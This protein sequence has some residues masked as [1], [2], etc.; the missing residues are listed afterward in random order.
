MIWKTR[1]ELQSCLN[2]FELRQ[3]LTAN[4][5]SI[6][7][8]ESKVMLWALLS[9]PQYDYPSSPLAFPPSLSPPSLL[10]SSLPSAPGSVCG[11]DGVRS[12]R[13]LPRVWGAAGRAGTRLP[14]HGGHLRL[15]QVL[16]RHRRPRERQM[17]HNRQA[18]GGAFPVSV[19]LTRQLCASCQCQ[20]DWESN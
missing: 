7:S 6:P 5:Q 19:L 16:L 2:M 15:D 8:G 17:D 13:T 4:K 11:R 12:A 9:T 3:M 18:Q 1:D 10:L 14:V 20:V